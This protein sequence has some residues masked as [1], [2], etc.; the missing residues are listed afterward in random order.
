VLARLVMIVALAGVAGC[1][2]PRA[3]ARPAP[4]VADAYAHYLRGR[5]AMLRGDYEAA[6]D[7]LHAANVAAPGEARIAVALVEAIWESGQHDAARD[8]VIAAQ[9]RW[10]DEPEVWIV[11]GA[12]HRGQKKFSEARAAYERAIA[13]DR[14]EERAWLGLAASWMA[15]GKPREAEATYGRLLKEVPDSVDGRY[16]LALRL[17]ARDADDD[18]EPHLRKVLELDPDHVDARLVLA[19][20]LRTRGKLD[21]AVVETRQAYDRTA[22]DPTVAEELFWLLCE[23]DDRQAALDLL[24]LVDDPAATLAT[25]IGVA[26]LYR[27]L[28]AFDDAIR[29]ADELRAGDPDSTGAKV[30]AAQARADR[31]RGDDLKDAIALAT[32]VPESDDNFPAARTLVVELLIAAK[33]LDR[34]LA[35]IEDA[36]TQRPRSID[37]LATHASVLNARGDAAE[38]RKLLE[39]ALARRPKSAALRYALAAFEDEAGDPARAARLAAEVVKAHE[40]HIAALNLAGYALTKAGTDLDRAERYLARARELAPGDP[41]VL[42]SWGWLLYRQGRLADAERALAHAA[43]LAPHQAEIQGH[44][45]EVRAKA[46]RPVKSRTAGH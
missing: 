11:A 33:D 21:D 14:T 22:G 34:A 3:P 39:D 42:D 9:E 43:H 2:P 37:L 29:L 35:V 7:E 46:G 10:P 24:G 41:S 1:P 12:V 36:R 38:G 31:G 17:I 8:A 40:D 15:L 4:L 32:S 20:S 13:L 28:G 26:D 18:A 23:A 5:L 30:V 16:E 44:L 6:V 25:R 19:R 27:Q 45:A